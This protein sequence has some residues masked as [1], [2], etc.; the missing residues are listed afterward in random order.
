M[1]TVDETEYS[2]ALCLT[3]DVDK[4]FK[5]PIHA[6]YY[7]LTER[8]PSHLRAVREDCNPYWQF[9]EIMR[10]ES[11][12]GVRSA[13]YWLNEPPIS[14][15]HR[16]RLSD[17][18]SL[19]QSVGRYSVHHPEI[20]DIIHR[21]DEGGWEI[22]LHGS[23]HTSEDGR[24][25]R[26]EKTRIEDL[27]GQSITGGRQHY[28]NLA[29]PETWSHYAEIGLKYDASLGSRTES[30]FHFGYDVLRPLDD[31]FV[32]F[33]LTLMEQ[34]LPD[35]DADFSSAW[36]EIDDLLETA[37][38]ESAVMTVLFHPRYFNATE[39]PGYRTIYRKLV[40]TALDRNAWVGSPAEYYRTVLTDARQPGTTHD[41]SVSVQTD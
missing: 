27:L 21:L 19:V 20:A 4:P 17:L 35:P 22:G 11:E 30:G 12:L 15:H 33:P 3:H 7:T 9:E 16:E 41:T 37:Q 32:V 29:V 1:T 13:F 34:H 36:A 10:L 40:E 39:F 24:R 26:S 6:V 25:L 31:E 18:Q 5:T 14:I 38:R 28:L 23:F 8:D 2:F